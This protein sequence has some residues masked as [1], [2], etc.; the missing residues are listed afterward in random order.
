MEVASVVEDRGEVEEREDLRACSKSITITSGSQDGA[1]G[2]KGLESLQVNGEVLVGENLIPGLR[3]ESC[4]SAADSADP[5]P[6]EVAQ[7]GVQVEGV[8]DGVCD[9]GED[10]RHMR[11]RDHGKHQSAD[12][13]VNERVLLESG[14]RVRHVL[15]LRLVAEA[16]EVPQDRLAEM[17]VA[18]VVEDRGEVEEREDLRA[19]SKSITITWEARMGHLAARDWKASR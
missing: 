11:D 5:S 1:V 3:R 7:E 10:I 9:G 16:L 17:E 13:G 12:P 2:S 4:P 19:C 15:V 8:R 18:S 14:D 6:L